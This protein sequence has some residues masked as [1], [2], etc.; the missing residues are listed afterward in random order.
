MA[1]GLTGRLETVRRRIRRLV[2]IHGGGTIS[3]SSSDT[4]VINDTGAHISTLTV[5]D[6]TALGALGASAVDLIGSGAV[7]VSLAVYNAAVTAGVTFDAGDNVT[8][9]DTGANIAA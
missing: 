9:A 4:F 6:M 3:L 2:L 1:N 7:A 8:L 5:G